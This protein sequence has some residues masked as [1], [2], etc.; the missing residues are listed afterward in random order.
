MNALAA[1]GAVRSSASRRD[2]LL[3]LAGLAI[4]ASATWSAFRLARI[5]ISDPG[6]PLWDEAA[7]CLASLRLAD[8]IRH[9]DVLTFLAVINQQ[10]VWPFVQPVLLMP[11]FLALGPGYDT[12]SVG[13]AVLFV[14]AT[15]ALFAAGAALHSSRGAWV[16]AASAALLLAAPYPHVFGTLGL[17]E[18]SG[19]FLLAT[20]V[21][22]H[23]RAARHRGFDVAA[24]LT[25]AALFLCKYNYGLLWL[26][27]LVWHEWTRLPAPSRSAATSQV[28]A[29]L[30]AGRWMQPMPLLVGAGGLAIAAILVTG[31]GVLDLLGHRVSVHSP[32]NL[33]YALYLIVIAWALLPVRRRLAEW[34]DR[35]D[36][37]SPHHRVMLVTIAFPLALWFVI[38]YPNRVKE[39][40]GFIVN[41]AAG[42]SPWSLEGLLYYPRAFASEY[43]PSPFVGWSVLALAFVP[44]RPGYRAATL[45]YRAL[46]VG[47]VATTLHR[48]HDPRF[49]FTVAP[50]VWL[51]A[52]RAASELVDIALRPLPSQARALLSGAVLVAVLAWVAWGSP[53]ESRVLAGHRAY[54]TSDVL[55]PVMDRVLDLA[56]EK[57]AVLLGYSNPLSPGLLAWHARRRRPERPHPRLPERAP[58]LA[59]GADESA[60]QARIAGLR[61]PGRLV[62]AAIPKP[63]SPAYSDAYRREVWADSVTAERLA[64]SPGVRHEADEEI[65]V[66][67]FRLRVFAFAN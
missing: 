21:A 25:T 66:A 47:L 24:G 10:V 43:S 17:T 1:T 39:F 45:V 52:A 55:A 15:I 12:G 48:Y 2:F 57:D 4:A 37:L 50:L 64:I 38:P 60:I 41:R 46:W 54:R 31:G 9:L 28:R 20:T 3:G 40:F 62:I 16:G 34:R 8:A 33:A 51:S 36:R 61:G 35:W 42:P 11:F 59:E 56:H 22:L 67:R 63:D 53:D 44:P 65:G 29:W 30:A 32:G 6:L 5:A 26:V 18:M 13:G 23:A 7:Q 27:P 19:A 14:A 58:W 49:L